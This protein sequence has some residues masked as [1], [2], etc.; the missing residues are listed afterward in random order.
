VATVGAIGVSLE[1][2]YLNEDGTTRSVA[3]A[4]TIDIYVTR[5]DLTEQVLTAAAY[6]TDGT[7][8]AV[9]AESTSTTFTIP[10]RY[11]YQA[12]VVDTSAGFTGFS[13]SYYIDVTRSP[14]VV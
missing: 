5:P 9:F 14:T 10:G 8:G 1:A 13:S 4:S 11:S 2:I 3:G 7:D 6:S 12:Y